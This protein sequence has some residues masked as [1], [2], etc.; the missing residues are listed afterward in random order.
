MARNRKNPGKKAQQN[1][2]SRIRAAIKSGKASAADRAWLASYEATKDE[3]AD[4]D[5]TAIDP[6]TDTDGDADAPTE[7]DPDHPSPVG[8]PSDAVDPP[9]GGTAAGSGPHRSPP[10]PAASV[11]SAAPGAPRAP[12][13]KLAPPPRINT[14]PDDDG[15]RSKEHG[16]DWRAKY[17]QGSGGQVPREVTVTKL[18]EQWLAVMT[19]LT[20]GMEAAG[21]KPLVD[22]QTIYPYV[23][24]E[25]DAVLPAHVELTPRMMAVGG[26]TVLVVQRFVRRKEIADAM[27]TE[28]EREAMRARAAQRREQANAAADNSPTPT[29][30]SEPVGSVE[31]VA[32]EAPAE[33]GSDAAENGSALSRMNGSHKPYQGM[34]AS[35]MIA[36]DPSVV[37]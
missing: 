8:T 26:T 21:I 22:P 37:M 4:A 25:I 14:K 31:A 11:S 12:R 29:G 27:K 24:L 34:S 35:E 13:A 17:K 10:P 7:P 28:A 33:T 20:Q 5:E 9:P 16:G 2:A 15:P 19:A 32:P 1:K 23:V 30:G 18:A 36:A 6:E 3:P